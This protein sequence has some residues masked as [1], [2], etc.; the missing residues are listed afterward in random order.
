MRKMTSDAR[1]QWLRD[2]SRPN[3]ANDE[4]ERTYTRRALKDKCERKLGRQNKKTRRFIA[5]VSLRQDGASRINQQNVERESKACRRSRK[6][7]KSLKIYN[8]SRAEQAKKRGSYNSQRNQQPPAPQKKKKMGPLHFSHRD[9]SRLSPRCRATTDNENCTSSRTRPHT[10]CRSSSRVHFFFPFVRS[11]HYPL[12]CPFSSFLLLSSSFFSSSFLSLPDAG[13]AGEGLHPRHWTD[14][15]CRWGIREGE[16]MPSLIEVL[17]PCFLLSLFLFLFFYYSRVDVKMRKAKKKNKKKKR[18]K[19]EN[20]RRFSSDCGLIDMAGRRRIRSWGC[21]GPYASVW[22][23]QNRRRRKEKR[24]ANGTVSLR[25]FYTTS[26]IF[27]KE[28]NA[29]NVDI[30]ICAIDGRHSLLP[31]VVDRFHPM[32]THTAQ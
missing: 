6:S 31:L 17:V 8:N 24:P 22:R 5:L 32:C 10:L 12:H 19:Q 28:N 29:R 14:V 1:W 23:R 21:F 20:Q 30:T 27:W 16:S 18:I 26:F 25:S 13:A 15:D 4:R 11:I 9:L 7:L 2:W 3:T